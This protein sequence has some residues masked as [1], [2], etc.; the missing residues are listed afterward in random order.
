MT[1]NESVSN[2]PDQSVSNDD[3]E[4]E[5]SVSYESHK[6]LLGQHKNAKATIEQLQK[7]INELR[8]AREAEEQAQL[9][10]EERFEELFRSAQQKVEELE[11]EKARIYQDSLNE[12]KRNVL[13]A[14]LGKVKSDEYLQFANFD[15]IVVT[16]DGSI[17]M[18]SV[19]EVANEFRQKHSAL[20]EQETTLPPSNAPSNAGKLTYEKWLSLSAKEKQDRLHELT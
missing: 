8:A 16:D 11:E 13:K 4:T 17:D 10:N 18:N 7:E 2:T 19:Q 14:E 15:A 6:K 1:E 3:Q 20:I 9:E 12:R 5:N